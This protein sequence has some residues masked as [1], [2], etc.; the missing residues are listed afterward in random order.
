MDLEVADGYKQLKK[1][2]G[3]GPCCRHGFEG[4]RQLFALRKLLFVL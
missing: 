4:G 3:G 1:Q 2:F